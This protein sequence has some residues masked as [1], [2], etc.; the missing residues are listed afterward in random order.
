METKDF[1]KMVEACESYYVLDDAVAFLSGDVGLVG[2]SVYK[3]AYVLDVTRNNSVFAGDEDEDYLK[4][5]T[6]IQDKS[7]S[8]NE[9]VDLLQGRISLTIS[10][11]MF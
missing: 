11:D 4:F 2:K 8:L 9:K 7:L 5:M 6:V 10:P 3:I 1:T